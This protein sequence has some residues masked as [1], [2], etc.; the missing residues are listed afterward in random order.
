MK[1]LKKHKE[2]ICG[3]LIVFILFVVFPAN[4]Y[5]AETTSCGEQVWI[6][7]MDFFII[8]SVICLSLVI[9]LIFIGGVT[10]DVVKL[11]ENTE[12]KINVKME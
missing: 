5:I 4:K 1:F 8:K 9:V 11:N 10:Q 7:D 3:S 12:D 6:E 2:T